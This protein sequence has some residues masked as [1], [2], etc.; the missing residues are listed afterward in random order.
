MSAK[1][2]LWGE[3]V[4]TKTRTPVAILREQASLLGEKTAFAIEAKVESAAS[5]R[6]FIHR[7]VLVVPALDQYEYELFSISHGIEL[8][9][10]QEL[11]NYKTMETEEQFKEWLHRQLSDSRTVR[12]IGNLLAQVNS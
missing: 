5:D 9:P 3:I 11:A 4:A 12:I 2:D 8:Y 10:V 6:G 7:F 1:T